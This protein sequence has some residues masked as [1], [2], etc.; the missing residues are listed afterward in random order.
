MDSAPRDATWVEIRNEMGWTRA[1]ASTDGK[2]Y[3][4][5]G[6]G[7]AGFMPLTGGEPTAWRPCAAER[8]RPTAEQIEDAVDAWHAST[9]RMTLHEALGWSSEEYDEWLIDPDAIPYRPLLPM[10]AVA[11]AG[12]GPPAGTKAST[13]MSP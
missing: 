9:S 8:G 1:I 7:L 5:A 4:A 12:M 13:G 10:P 6:S 11:T 2:W 3:V